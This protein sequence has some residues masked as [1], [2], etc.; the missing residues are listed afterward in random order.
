MLSNLKVEGQNFDFLQQIIT[1]QPKPVIT[2][3][4]Y[5]L[6]THLKNTA[7]LT[8]APSNVNKS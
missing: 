8:S 3:Q 5:Q 2:Y 1:D 6:Q 7:D 4:N